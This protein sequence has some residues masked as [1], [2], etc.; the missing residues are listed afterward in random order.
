MQHTADATEHDA[1]V[2]NDG[3]PV[4]RGAGIFEQ[5]LG[6]FDGKITA[7]QRAGDGFAG[8]ENHPAIRIVPVEPAFRAEIDELRTEE[9]ARQRGDVNQHEPLIAPRQPRPE[10]DTHENARE[11]QPAVGGGVK[12]CEHRQ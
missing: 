9:C 12:R 5:A 1:D 4:A 11:H 7:E 6:D 8:G 2:H 10:N 3:E